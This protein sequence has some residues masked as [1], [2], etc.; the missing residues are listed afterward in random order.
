MLQSLRIKNL[1]LLDEAALDFEA[2]FT[3]VTGETGAG[4]SILLGALALLAGERAEKTIIRQGA[5]ACEVE[6]ALYFEQPKKIDALLAGLDL[7]ACED[8]RLVLK[9]SLSR[10]KAPKITVNGGL[11]T[12]AALQRLGEHWIDFHGPGEPRRLLKESCQLELLDLFGRAGGALAT[13]Q[14]KYGAWRGLLAEREQLAHETRLAPEQLAFL[15]NQLA[16]LDALELTAEAVET[17]ERDSRRVAHAQELITLAETLSAGLTGE[18]GVQTSLAAQVRAA[19]QLAALDAASQPLADRLGATAIELNELG[20][21]YAALAESLVFDDGQAEQLQARLNTWLEAKRRH[22]GDL[23][24]VVAARDDLRHRLEAQGDLEGALARLDLRLAEQEQAMKKAAGN[25]R[26]LREKSAKDLAKAAAKGMA[27]LGFRRAD[28][29]VRIVPLAAPGPTGDCG[30]EFCSPRMSGSL[31]CPSTGWRQ[32]ASSPA[33]CSRSRRCWPTSTPCRCWC[34]TRWTR[35]WAG[36][37]AAWWARKW[38]PSPAAGRCF[39]SPT[40]RRSR[41]RATR[42]LS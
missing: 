31:C 22:G 14:E 4:K 42:I 21:E 18:D 19:K 29:S 11:A 38:P 34:L 12:L 1:A 35:T 13:Y 17:L 16:S 15:Q 2:G 25:L 8:G 26:T 33:S 3:V 39:A 36:K 9:R 10:D 40:S 32:A 41:R 37:S 23:A 7:P 6:A 30:T 27:Q 20:A 24:A 5:S 28:F